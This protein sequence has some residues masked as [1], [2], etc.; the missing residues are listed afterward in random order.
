VTDPTDSSADSSVE[1]PDGP[2]AEPVPAHPNVPTRAAV[3]LAFAGVLVAGLLGALIGWGLV[4]TGCDGDCGLALAVGT[5]IGAA[6]A[7]TG[8]GIVAVLVL[9]AMAEWRAH[10]PRG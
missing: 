1:P 7:A 9:R 3:A 2:P 5:I 6:L 10:P 8:A 4:D